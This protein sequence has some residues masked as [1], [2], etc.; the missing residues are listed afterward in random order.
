MKRALFT[1]ILAIAFGTV[2]AQDPSSDAKLDQEQ[3][4]V[5][6]VVMEL[7]DAYR[8][9]DTARLS[10]VFTADA[11]MN[12]IAMEDGKPVVSRGEVSGFIKWVSTVDKYLDEQLWNYRV[13][14]DGNLASVWTDFGIWVDGEFSHCGVDSFLL[15]NTENGWK[16]FELSDTNRREDCNVPDEIRKRAEK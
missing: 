16:I 1:L 7:F 6:K 13:D 11:Q 5:M 3:L 2:I 4:K 14:I 15:L 8:A 9:L 10:A 12:R